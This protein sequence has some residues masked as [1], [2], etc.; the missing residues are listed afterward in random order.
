MNNN[1]VGLILEDYVFL[2]YED[3]E[4]SDFIME[5]LERYSSNV[6]K[7][8]LHLDLKDFIQILKGT[9][10][11][12]FDDYPNFYTVLEDDPE[13]I[14]STVV[15][16]TLDTTDSV[17]ILVTSSYEPDYVFGTVITYLLAYV[18]DTIASK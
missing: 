17:D 3:R 5:H 15:A 2:M 14:K 6:K 11:I 7:L 16:Y 13:D 10:E 12:T 4:S 8:M 18:N 9:K 1:L